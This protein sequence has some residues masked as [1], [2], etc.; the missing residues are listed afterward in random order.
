MTTNYDSARYTYFYNMSFKPNFIFHFPSDYFF[1][2]IL[3]LWKKKMKKKI[4]EPLGYR[5]SMVRM[6]GMITTF[7]ISFFFLFFFL[8]RRKT[9]LRRYWIET[10]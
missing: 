8:L 9:K 10:R 3:R 1:L 5:F 4:S 6:H 2:F 7:E